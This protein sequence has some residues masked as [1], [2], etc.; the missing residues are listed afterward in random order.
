MNEKSR[1]YDAV[2][3]DVASANI[4]QSEVDNVKQ[5]PLPESISYNNNGVELEQQNI[6]EKNSNCA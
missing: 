5:I 2:L 3:T 6:I 1:K 4:A